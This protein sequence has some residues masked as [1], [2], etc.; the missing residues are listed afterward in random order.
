MARP[1]PAGEGRIDGVRI[2]VAY[3]L[4]FLRSKTADVNGGVVAVCFVGSGVW[5][6]PGPAMGALPSKFGVTGLAVPPAADTKRM[7]PSWFQ[8]AQRPAVPSASVFAGPLGDIDLLQFAQREN[9]MDRLSG[10]QKG[11]AAFSVPSKARAESEPSGRTHNGLPA[12]LSR[13][14]TATCSGILALPLA[15]IPV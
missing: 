7:T 13:T 12:R 1:I 4:V 9:P 2:G 14:A 10:D 3:D 6:K 11:K 5:L 8:D 15:T